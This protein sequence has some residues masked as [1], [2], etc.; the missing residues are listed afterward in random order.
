MRMKR[1]RV[2]DFCFICDFVRLLGG[3]VS[4]MCVSEW[5]RSQVAVVCVTIN[6]INLDIGSSPFCNAFCSVLLIFGRH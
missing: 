3:I 2:F 4:W 6:S 5:G 1:L